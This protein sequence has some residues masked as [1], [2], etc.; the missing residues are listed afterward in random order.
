[1]QWIGRTAKRVSL[2]LLVTLQLMTPT[3]TGLAQIG[4]AEPIAL[5]VPERWRDP[6]IQF[7]ASLGLRDPAAVIANTKFATL[8]GSLYRPDSVVF[9]IED[10]SACHEDICLTFIGRLVDGRLVADAQFTAG[11]RITWSDHMSEGLP[12]LRAFLLFFE[13]ST[14]TS[15][16]FETAT[17]WI[18]FPPSK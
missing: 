14:G 2:T 5:A 18:V 11:P 16:L 15:R 10:K 1:M 7:L 13:G 17:G 12:G 9:R 4:L 8:G 6:Y 3:T